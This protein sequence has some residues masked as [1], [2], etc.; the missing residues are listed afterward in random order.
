MSLNT[1]DMDTE[2]VSGRRLQGATRLLWNAQQHC[3]R[4]HC[5]R[6]MQISS[7]GDFLSSSKHFTSSF[8]KKDS[9]KKVKIQSYI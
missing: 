1:A 9:V 6:A 5:A 7:G 2:G 3:W 4:Q 8:K